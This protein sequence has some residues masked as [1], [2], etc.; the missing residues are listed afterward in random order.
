MQIR[1]FEKGLIKGLVQRCGHDIAEKIGH[2]ELIGRN[3][4]GGIG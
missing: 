4:D 3:Q 1:Q 2:K